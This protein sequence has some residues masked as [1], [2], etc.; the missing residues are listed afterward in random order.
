MKIV[1]AEKEIDA[2]H[3]EALQAVEAQDIPT[4]VAVNQPVADAAY[5]L[6]VQDAL[7]WLTGCSEARPG[8]DRI[9]SDK[10]TA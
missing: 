5:W 10:E 3:D 9:D 4:Y 8:R 7:D 1:R 2:L 6:G